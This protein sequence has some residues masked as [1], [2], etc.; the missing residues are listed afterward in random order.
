MV[1]LEI[2]MDSELVGKP[3]E[4]QK[5]HVRV[6]VFFVWLGLISELML[7]AGALVWLFSKVV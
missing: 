6:F 5:Q 4:I 3:L 7:H 2:R 1:K